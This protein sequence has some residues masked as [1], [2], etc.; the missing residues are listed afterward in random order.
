MKVGGSVDKQGR[1]MIPAFDLPSQ[2]PK[3]SVSHIRETNAKRNHS[4][5]R[6]QANCTSSDTKRL[7]WGW[8]GVTTREQAEIQLQ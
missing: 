7:G 6:T 3:V 4:A 1:A 2:D 8:N 5:A